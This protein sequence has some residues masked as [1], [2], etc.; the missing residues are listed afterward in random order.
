MWARRMGP[1]LKCCQSPHSPLLRL[2]HP[3]HFT[4]WP[5]W[6]PRN[7][8]AVVH[9]SFPD[10]QA[11]GYSQGHMFCLLSLLMEQFFLGCSAA[12]YMY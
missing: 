10:Q 1:A 5:P 11:S 8:G 7:W 6:P 3:A 9:D 2:P 12:R 4:P